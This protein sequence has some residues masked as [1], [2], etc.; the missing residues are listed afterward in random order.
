[1][2][3]I[4]FFFLNF[5][6]RPL[7]G[8][9]HYTKIYGISHLIVCRRDG[10]MNIYLLLEKFTVIKY[11]EPFGLHWGKMIVFMMRYLS[12]GGRW[13]KL[14]SCTRESMEVLGWHN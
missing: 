9:V 11:I 7:H 8:V 4:H 5:G 2:I 14:L 1:M 13:A 10:R 3:K 6:V 12:L